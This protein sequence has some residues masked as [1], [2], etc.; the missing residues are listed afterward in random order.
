MISAVKIE[1]SVIKQENS[2][3]KLTLSNA[4]VSTSSLNN[5]TLINPALAEPPPAS[6]EGISHNN[7]DDFHSPQQD[8]QWSSNGSSSSI[9]SV[10]FDDLIDTGY[11]H[12]SPENDFATT[13]IINS[14]DIFNFPTNAFA[15]THSE[16]SPNFS[17]PQGQYAH[18]VQHVRQSSNASGILSSSTTM[19]NQPD[20]SSIAL[21]FIL[22]YVSQAS[23]C[24]HL[25]KSVSNI[26]AALTFTPHPPSSTQKETH[27]VTNSWHQ[28][29]STLTPLHLFST[30]SIPLHGQYQHLN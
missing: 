15:P 25:K 20:T 6:S 14:P 11:L 18:Q 13:A 29:S 23:H 30:I 4:N 9:V 1:T 27:P 3:I 24:I 28:P 2:D 17:R 22:A 8:M 26:H 12:V 5:P 19:P 10:N 7:L 21:N 16:P